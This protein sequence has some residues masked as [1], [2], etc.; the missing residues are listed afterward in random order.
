LKRN[1]H[2]RDFTQG[3]EQSMNTTLFE[4]ASAELKALGL[5]LQQLPGQYRVSFRNGGAA[6]ATT[7]DDLQSAIMWGREMAANLPKPKEPPL[8]PMGPRATRRGF[9][10]RHNRKIAAR[11]RGQATTEKN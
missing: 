3:K 10:Y 2:D 11:R 1:S 5:V 8:G 7:T 9:M 4:K 6:T